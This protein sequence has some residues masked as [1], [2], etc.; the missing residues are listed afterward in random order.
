[1]KDVAGKRTMRG[2]PCVLLMILLAVSPV[3]VAAQTQPVE[4]RASEDYRAVGVGT[5]EAAKQRALAIAWRNVLREAAFHLR[6]LPE[7]NAVPLKANHLEAFLPVIVVMEEDL[8]SP[9]KVTVVARLTV[10]E[11]VRRLDQLRKDS[12]AATGLMESWQEIERLSMQL[13]QA[14]VSEKDQGRLTDSVNAYRLV[15]HV[16]AALAKTEESPASARVPSLKGRQRAWQLAEIAVAMGPDL[17]QA[18]LAMG[19]VL[20]IENQRSAAEEEYR[21]AIVLNPASISA[22]IKLA[23]AVRL[24]DKTSEA[25]AELREALRLDQGSAIAHNDLGFIFGTQ[26]DTAG[27]IAEYE[28]AVRLDPDL[29]D[30]RNNLG[31]ALARAGR[32]P[33]AVAQFQEIIRIDPDSVLGYRNLGIALADMEKDDLSA[34]AFRHIVRINPT[35]FN[36]RY[37]LGELFRLEGKYD[38][39]VKQFR[40]Y[41]RLAPDTPQNQRNIRRASDFIG[42]HENP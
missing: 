14:G 4:I 36:A 19:D 13:L 38:E 35:H 27:A 5:A 9:G 23:E 37:D 3:C 32:I 18:H 2:T 8:A 6:R 25:I 40:E 7:V 20:L 34:E 1:M 17:P 26:Q 33:E 16:Y 11:T 22:R 24:D 21:R 10:S 42:T 39:A 31:I 15:A 28:E 41:L 29:I 12:A 30:A